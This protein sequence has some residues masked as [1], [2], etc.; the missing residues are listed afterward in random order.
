MFLYDVS[1][2]GNG[3]A[4]IPMAPPTLPNFS[5][6]LLSNRGEENVGGTGESGNVSFRLVIFYPF[7]VRH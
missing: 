4:S 3:Y 7:L 6:T 2:I 1:A 5:V